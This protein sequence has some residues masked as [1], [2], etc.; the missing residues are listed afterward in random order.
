MIESFFTGPLFDFF[1][2]IAIL[3]MLIIV[4]DDATP[5]FLHFMSCVVEEE[6]HF[7]WIMFLWII[8]KCSLKIDENS[9]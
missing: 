6:A 4:R 1:Y 2:S 7:I 8:F 9:A 3:V 5:D